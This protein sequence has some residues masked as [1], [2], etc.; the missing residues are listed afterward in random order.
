M[1]LEQLEYVVQIANSHSMS[2]AA[3]NLHTSQQNISKAIKQLEDELSFKIFTR[4]THGAFL[5]EEG[6]AVYHT[7]LDV[8]QDIERLLQTCAMPTPNYLVKGDLRIISTSCQITQLTEVFWQMQQKYPNINIFL[9]AKEYLD[10]STI[11]DYFTQ[12]KFDVIC[13]NVSRDSLKNYLPLKKICD[14]FLLREESLRV[15]MSR[16]SPL[17]D[18]KTL[19]LKTLSQ[20][21]LIG[22]VSNIHETPYIKRLMAERGLSAKIV[23]SCTNSQAAIEYLS[24]GQVYLLGTN[25]VMKSSKAFHNKYIRS[26]PLKEKIIIYHLMIIPKAQAASPLMRIFLDL[27]RSV[28]LQD[29]SLIDLSEQDPSK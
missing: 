11:I 9:E 19:S 26:M 23:F 1:R 22:F 15:F 27:F 13:L 25:Y 24:N 4:S 2:D 28:H 21:P 8:L 14:I 3:V 7:A 17:I 16:D 29:F 20:L 6:E 10:C 5:T 12:N 18:Q